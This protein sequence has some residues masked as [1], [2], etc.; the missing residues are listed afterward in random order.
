MKVQ[1]IMESD[2]YQFRI[3]AHPLKSLYTKYS[4]SDITPHYQCVRPLGRVRQERRSAAVTKQL[5]HSGDVHVSH[6]GFNG[7]NDGHADMKL[8]SNKRSHGDRTKPRDNSLSADAHERDNSGFPSLTRSR[9]QMFENQY[10]IAASR[11]LGHDTPSPVLRP[12]KSFDK[13]VVHLPLFQINLKTYVG[14]SEVNRAVAKTRESLRKLMELNKAKMK[15]GQIANIKNYEFSAPTSASISR[16]NTNSGK[17]LIS[18]PF[19]AKPALK[20]SRGV[21][22]KGKSNASKFPVK[23]GAMDTTYKGAEDISNVREANDMTIINSRHPSEV[24]GPDDEPDDSMMSLALRPETSLTLG[25]TMHHI[26]RVIKSPTAEELKELSE[27]F[28]CGDVQSAWPYTEEIRSL[29]TPSQSQY[30]RSRTPFSRPTTVLRE[31]FESPD[32]D[33]I[34][35]NQMIHRHCTGVAYEQKPVLRYTSKQGNYKLDPIVVP[36]HTCTDCP[37]CNIYHRDVETPCPPNT[38]NTGQLSLDPGHQHNQVFVRGTRM[39]NIHTKPEVMHITRINMN[40]STS[41]SDE[42]TILNYVKPL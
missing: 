4:P 40:G 9:T 26:D 20:S 19:H 1:R 14:E 6:S 18:Q 39:N 29:Y 32:E 11:S 13:K 25:T 21:D 15:N 27:A 31:V 34:Q 42:Q 33:F 8:N 22:I 16:E 12:A 5:R 35:N 17:P 30:R 28:K 3:E 38:P 36:S 7:N 37:M 10:R 23:F 41:P 2:Q 24:L